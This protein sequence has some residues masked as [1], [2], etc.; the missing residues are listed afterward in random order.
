M[1][2]VLVCN[3]SCIYLDQAKLTARIG[4]G[5]APLLLLI[6]L[7]LGLGKLNPLYK[8]SSSTCSTPPDPC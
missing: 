6:P 8:V 3:E 2:Q 5:W 1:Y 7:R 4:E